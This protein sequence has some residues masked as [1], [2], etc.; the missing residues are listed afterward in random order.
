M[1]SNKF[2]TFFEKLKKQKIAEGDDSWKNEV[3]PPHGSA[4][5]RFDLSD[6]E[7]LIEALKSAGLV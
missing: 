6:R 5:K 7:K 3:L 1:A 2:N 4:N